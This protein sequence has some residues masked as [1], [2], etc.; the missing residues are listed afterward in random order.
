M[1]INT[2]AVSVEI[3]GLITQNCLK[4]LVSTISAYYNRKLYESCVLWK[5]KAIWIPRENQTKIKNSIRAIQGQVKLLKKILQTKVKSV[6]LDTF[7]LICDKSLQQRFLSN[8]EKADEGTKSEHQQEIQNLNKELAKLQG[9]TSELEKKLKLLKNR[10][11][12]FKEKVQEISNK[13]LDILNNRKKLAKEKEEEVLDRTE[14]L[15]EENS[16]LKEKIE[17]IE[18]NVNNFLGEMGGLLELTE[19]NQR[20]RERRRTSVKKVK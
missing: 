4:G 2:G 9:S 15:R 5:N 7:L 14:E 17:M 12:S 6:F 18:N 3:A 20:L 13:K 19:E 10:E 16:G 1:E 8:L 11:G